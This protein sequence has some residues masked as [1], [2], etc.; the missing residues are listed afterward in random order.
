MAIHQPRTRQ[1]R[2]FLANVEACRDAGVNVGKTSV[3][4]YDSL[5]LGLSAI[6]F[7]GTGWGPC[8]LTD[9]YLSVL[10]DTLFDLAYDQGK[11]NNV[12]WVGIE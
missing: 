7:P 5:L 12:K 2:H 4:V 8:A 1:Q 3:T 6:Q 9:E 11:H 10:Q